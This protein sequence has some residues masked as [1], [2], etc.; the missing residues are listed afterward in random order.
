MA[1]RRRDSEREQYWR[2]T[3]ARWRA[4]GL[5]IRAFCRRQRLTESAFHFW[6]RE[7]LLRESAEATAVPGSP[8]FVPVT[9]IPTA[10]VA[11]EVRC[12]S[13]HVVTLSAYDA[14]S[15]KSL[16]AALAPGAAC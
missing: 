10:T 4:S 5:S 8:T 14:S 11:V 16:F 1:G 7:L 2:T 12:P 13:G 3:V 15:L 6:R 9:V